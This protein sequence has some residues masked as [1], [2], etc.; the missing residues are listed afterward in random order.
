M[1]YRVFPNHEGDLPNL[2]GF[3][4]GPTVINRF[5]QSGHLFTIPTQ[6]QSRVRVFDYFF[7]LLIS[8]Q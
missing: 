1:R 2:H 4:T 3:L 6:K 7:V 8:A 5:S